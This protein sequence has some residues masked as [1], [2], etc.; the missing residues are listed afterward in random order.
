MSQLTNGQ[1]NVACIICARRKTLNTSSHVL[2]KENRYSYTKL[3]AQAIVAKRTVRC[4]KVIGQRKRLLLPFSWLKPRWSHVRFV[5]FPTLSGILPDHPQHITPQC[6][7]AK[8]VTAHPEDGTKTVSMSTNN[9]TLQIYYETKI[10]TTDESR[11][12]VSRLDPRCNR[13][14]FVSSATFSGISP[15]Q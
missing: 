7:T 8:Y 9:L 12:P 3:E 5:R 15:A 6:K 10:D 4:S 2:K 13:L 1:E 11:L 14:R